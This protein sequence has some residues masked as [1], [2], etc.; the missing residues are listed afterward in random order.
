MKR[1]GK[2][3]KVLIAMATSCTLLQFTNCNST[4]TSL[5]LNAG[6]Q[7]AQVLASSLINALFY[8][9]GNAGRIPLNQVGQLPV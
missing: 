4:V 6:N 3:A 2:F 8:S 9:I 1:P 5:V 7:S